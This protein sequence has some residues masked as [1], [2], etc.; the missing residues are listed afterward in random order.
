MAISPQKLLPQSGSTGVRMSSSIVRTSNLA[1]SRRSNT[2]LQND[3]ATGGQ[4][5]LIT[6]YSSL[7]EI[8]KILSG[9]KKDS[10][11]QEVKKKQEEDKKE[12]K[13]E[14]DKLEFKP[15]K[16]K[17]NLPKIQTPFASFFDRLKNSLVL[18][19]VGWLVNRFWDYVPKILEGVS[20]F[21]KTLES[22]RLVLKPA[23]DALG[24]ALYN[25][26]LVGTKV[27]GSITGAQI[28]K[29]EKDLA[30]AINELDKK[31]SIINALMA[32]IVIGDIF[33]AVADGLDLFERPSTGVDSGR[34]GGDWRTEGNVIRGKGGFKQAYDN[35]LKKG[36]LSQG[37]KFVV[38]DYKR[39]IKAGYHPDS[40]ARQ[41]FFRNQSFWESARNVR[42]GGFSVETAKDYRIA[43][44]GGIVRSRFFG[45]GVTRVAGKVFGRIPIIG[46]LIDFVINLAMGE[47]PG[48]AAA[49]AVGATV[50]S[51]LGTFV[52]V[53]FV[54]TILGGVLGDLLGGAVYDFFN[55]R[56]SAKKGPVKR[57]E[58]P[59]GYF[60]GGLIGGIRNFFSR[61]SSNAPKASGV[62]SRSQKLVQQTP[63]VAQT[64]KPFS[65]DETLANRIG[66][67]VT[68][69]FVGVSQALSSIPFVGSFVA[70]GLNLAL[71]KERFTKSAAISVASGIGTLL[72]NPLSIAIYNFLDK[73]MPGLGKLVQKVVGKSFGIFLTNWITQYLGNQLYNEIYPMIDFIKNIMKSIEGEA[74]REAQKT[75]DQIQEDGVVE[76]VN[77]PQGK[78]EK[79][80]QAIAFY[81]S[82]GF[83]D[84][85][86]AY[87]VGNLLQESGLRPD[88]VGDNGKAFGLAQWRIDQAAGA[89]WLGYKRWAKQ[90]N[91]QIGDFFAQLEYT[92]VEGQK[93]NAG[94]S[95]M[96]GSDRSA[97]KNFIRGYEGYS[98]EGNRFGFAEDILKN[99]EKYGLS[100]RKGGGGKAIESKLSP[101]NIKKSKPQSISASSYPQI[102]SFPSYD[103]DKLQVIRQVV[104]V[105][106]AQPQQPGGII[107]INVGGVNNIDYQVAASKASI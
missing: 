102:S 59:K 58:K 38:R 97:H 30:V 46:G 24:S 64:S 18:L 51:A 19:F 35:M 96:K 54:G 70:L 68:E 95:M 87:M 63:T 82:K 105:P 2:S 104:Y 21:M 3:T 20:N 27:L 44:R 49:K 31:F 40:A 89:R 88:A 15:D 98:V 91:K 53:P 76:S 75:S 103:K 16:K 73:A 94:L 25:I 6:I 41:A 48:R 101:T 9:R 11:K 43:A 45:R 100:K 22:I 84:T 29:N 8:D 78:D 66:K 57:T 83:S 60:L 50:G 14:E 107:P 52:P 4:S 36:N 33:S 28:D 55:D 81:K 26:T 12:K 99:A 7:V 74:K 5:S 47:K 92:I 37:E 13:V 106:V 86:A 90:N 39:L 32:G 72:G 42:G 85:G 71:A 56:N 79:I 80:K 62:T 17:I 61:K 93:Y 65:V 77:V 34:R 23:T 1:I 67:K 69:G 10:G